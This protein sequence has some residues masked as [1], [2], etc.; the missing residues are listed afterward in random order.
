LEAQVADLHLSTY[1]DLIRL[2][3]LPKVA[4]AAHEVRPFTALVAGLQGPSGAL[5]S[6]GT[7]VDPRSYPPAGLP[8]ASPAIPSTR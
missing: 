8:D 7:A 3:N 6:L 1:A 5:P 4:T 2:A